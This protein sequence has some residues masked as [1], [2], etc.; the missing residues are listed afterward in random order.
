M[1]EHRMSFWRWLRHG[2]CL[3]LFLTMLPLSSTAL[4][5]FC[6]RTFTGAL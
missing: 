3:C 1:S 2:S 5:L 6:H 4:Q